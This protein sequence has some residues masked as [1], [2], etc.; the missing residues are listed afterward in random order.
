[1]ESSNLSWFLAEQGLV[2]QA[3][4]REVFLACPKFDSAP[5][6]PGD[7]CACLGFFSLCIMDSDVHTQI[8]V[9]AYLLLFLVFILPNRPVP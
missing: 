7:V 4:D 5:G 8:S 2:Q 9:V 3:T 6:Q 1:M